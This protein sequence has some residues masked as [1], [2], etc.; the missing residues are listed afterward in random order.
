[1]LES[2]ISDQKRIVRGEYWLRARSALRA[3]D[4]AHHR[5]WKIL[6]IAGPAP[7]EEIN[8]IRECMHQ[9]HITA[10]DLVEDNVLAAIDAGADEAHTLN[11]GET[12]KVTN[13]VGSYSKIIPPTVLADEKFDVISLDLTGPANDWLK[14]VVACYF[15]EALVPKGAMMVTF[16]YGRDVVEAMNG[17]WENLRAKAAQMD[18]YSYNGRQHPSYPSYLNSLELLKDVPQSVAIRVW[19]ALRIRCTDL[20]SIVQYRG[21]HMPMVSCFLRS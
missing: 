15:R 1:M 2:A 3:R 10:V 6:T 4:H 16:S 11:I 19:S 14:D 5:A 7:A 9:A 17:E 8:S 21:G 18:T 20:E 13:G 12:R